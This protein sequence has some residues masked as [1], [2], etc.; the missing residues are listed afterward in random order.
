MLIE[1]KIYHD[2][3]HYIAIPRYTR[4]YRAKFKKWKYKF[5]VD[6]DLKPVKEYFPYGSSNDEWHDLQSADELERLCAAHPGVSV[7]VVR[8]MTIDDI[9]NEAYK[10]TDGMR[11]G[12]RYDALC[13]KVR[14]FIGDADDLGLFVVDGLQKKRRNMIT[15]RVRMARKAALQEF[16]YFCTFTYDDRLHTEESFQAD[17]AKDLSRRVSNDGWRYIYVWERSPQKHRLHL[18]G[19]FY[20]PDGTLPGVTIERNDYN[21]KRH[22]RVRTLEDSYFTAK[23]GRNDIEP[24][25]GKDDVKESLRYMLKYMEKTNAKIVYSKGLYEYFCAEVM[26]SDVACSM[27]RSVDSE[28][29]VLFDDFACFSKGMYVG[30]VS[31]ETIAQ[32]PKIT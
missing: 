19:I 21:F 12:E 16:N 10:Q 20:I 1:A 8:Q 3:S 32:L 24:I 11:H 13:A 25:N 28:R 22:E 9:F 29:Y 30:R 15:R 17:L 6:Q 14:P 7:P 26:N 23:F 4:P 18:H 31:P 5:K 27:G 2:G